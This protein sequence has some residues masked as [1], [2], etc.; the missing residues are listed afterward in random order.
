MARTVF[1]TRPEQQNA[2]LADLLRGESIDVHI[3]PMLEIVPRPVDEPFKRVAMKLDR[4]DHIVFVS[5]NAVICALDGLEDFWPQWPVALRW[6]AV[7]E[8]TGSLLR[9]RQIDVLVPREHSTEGMLASGVFD[10]V[11]GARL[12]IVRGGAG[13]KFLAQTLT[14][15]GAQV[16][17]LEVYARRPVSLEAS[18]RQALLARLPAVVVAYSGETLEALVANLREVPEGLSIVVPWGRVGNRAASLGFADVT[19]ARGSDEA[20]LV[21]A[22]RM[23]L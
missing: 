6:H 11:A 1:L 17:Y 14:E 8:A 18:Q 3:L 4:Y 15:R 23:V 19:V 9:A 7:G 20:A 5:Q 21:A 10:D 12:L 13:R 16:D 2:R 22:I